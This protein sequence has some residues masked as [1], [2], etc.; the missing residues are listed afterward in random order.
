MYFVAFEIL[1]IHI[2][3]LQTFKLTNLA[4]IGLETLIIEFFMN[5]FPLLCINGGIYNLYAFILN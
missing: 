4:N 2:V 1:N 3:L 5:V